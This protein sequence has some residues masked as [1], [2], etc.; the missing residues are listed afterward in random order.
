MEGQNVL[1]VE[2]DA[3]LSELVREVLAEAGYHP[4]VISDHA[5]IA[6]SVKQWRPRCVLLD[7][8]LLSTGASRSWHD[9]AALHRVDPELPVV[10]LTADTEAVREARLGRTYRSRAAAF[11]GI[12]GKPFDL[13]ELLA[14]VR[15]VVDRSSEPDLFAMIVHELR[16]P[17]T[18]IRGHVQAARRHLGD[19]QDAQRVAMDRTLVQVDRMGVLIGQI[20]DHARLASDHFSMDVTVVDIADVVAATVG[21]HRYDRSIA[22]E[23]PRTPALVYGDAARIAQIIDNLVSNALKYS[24]AGTPVTVAVTVNAL[25]AQI[26]VT[27]RGVGVPEDERALLFNPFYR[28]TRTRDIGGTGLGLYLCKQLAS[29]HSGRLWLEESSTAGSVFVLAIPLASS[30]ETSL[31]KSN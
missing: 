6:Q 27:D 9:A 7:G 30:A 15:A 22:F 21:D 24:D 31:A 26:R 4:I 8:E 12:I 23:R 29:R 5:L 14:V 19:G 2:D 20:L 17:L 11:A 28:T 10:L 1:V 3:A 13:E 16:Q 18:I 25:E